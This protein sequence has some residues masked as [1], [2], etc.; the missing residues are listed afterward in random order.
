MQKTLKELENK[1]VLSKL[2]G[3]ILCKLFDFKGM[4]Y[5]LLAYERNK[6]R[7]SIKDFENEY[8]IFLNNSLDFIPVYMNVSTLYR[9]DKKLF[10]TS[11][12]KNKKIILDKNTIDVFAHEHLLSSVLDFTKYDTEYRGLIEITSENNSTNFNILYLGN[13]I[14]FYFYIITNITEMESEYNDEIAEISKSSDDPNNNAAK[15]EWEAINRK[16]NIIHKDI[17]WE[18]SDIEEHKE[19]SYEIT[20]RFKKFVEENNFE[21]YAYSLN[22]LH[23]IYEGLSDGL[24]VKEYL[25][26]NLEPAEMSWIMKSLRTKD[27]I[28]EKPDESIS[29]GDNIFFSSRIMKPLTIKSKIKK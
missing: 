8:D 16:I 22:Q 5:F 14:K 24:N 28:E 9:I 18:I 26:P 3:A 25:D 27:E 13:E 17:L 1:V 20:R 10:Q 6:T 23:L 29:D 4:T 11:F 21:P 2:K 15:K 7:R 19:L 12:V